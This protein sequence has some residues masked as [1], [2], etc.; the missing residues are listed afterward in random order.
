MDNYTS[1]TKNWLDERYKKTSGEG[2]Y[3]PH[4]P[5][6]GFRKK[7]YEDPGSVNFRYIVTYQI[8]KALSQLQFSSLLDVGGSEGYKLALAHSIFDLNRLHNGDLSEE[9]CRRAKEIFSIDGTAVDIHHLPYQDNEFDVVLCSESLEHVS[10]IQSAAAE[11]LRVAGKALVITVPHEPKELIEKN[12]RE[13]IPHG[14]IHSLGLHSF[15][16]LLKS[17]S[18]V[19]TR[20]MLSPLTRLPAIFL[21]AERKTGSSFPRFLVSIYNFF[22]PL[23]AKIFG[24]KSVSALLYLDDFLANLVP[25]YSGMI[26]I[27]LK[28]EKCYSKVP[29]K[30]FS[31]S[32][33]LDFQ[34]PY[35][36]LKSNSR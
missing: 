1:I 9:A 33:I 5:I 23:L 28:D 15:D 19:I 30:Q 18:V 20:R 12:I 16:Y 11:L 3:F 7:P 31:V 26:F 27:F 24:K 10:D 25:L 29:Q 36:Y 17:A 34:V 13:Q 35:H 6:Y 14:H 4:Q 8:I 22:I 2:I 21:S 32:Q